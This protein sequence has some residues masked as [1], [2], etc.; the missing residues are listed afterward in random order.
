[1][2]NKA[3]TI[4]LGMMIGCLW[5]IPNAVRGQSDQE[6]D[7]AAVSVALSSTDLPPGFERTTETLYSIELG[8]GTRYPGY[9]QEWTSTSAPYSVEHPAVIMAVYAVLSNRPSGAVA[10]WC[11]QRQISQGGVRFP[12]HQA[13]A[14][15]YFGGPPMGFSLFQVD[16]AVVWL[17]VRGVNGQAN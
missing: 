10:L 7:S 15:T 13:L 3:V 14:D 2:R 8:P 4:L 16:R 11:L 5:L 6:P 1:M 12:E 9:I 17:S